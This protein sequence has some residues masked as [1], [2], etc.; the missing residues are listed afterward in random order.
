MEFEKVYRL[1]LT[2]SLLLFDYVVNDG[3]SPRV[4]QERGYFDV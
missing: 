3:Y 4:A 1:L 2:D